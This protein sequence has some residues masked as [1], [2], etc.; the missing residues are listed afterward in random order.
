MQ[1]D[2]P[3]NSSSFINSNE[4][5]N[6]K[7]NSISSKNN[8]RDFIKNPLINHFTINS[9][10]IFD[11]FDF[12]K[13][14]SNLKN[15]NFIKLT[16]SELLFLKT[17]SKDINTKIEIIDNKSFIDVDKDIFENLKKF[18][19]VNNELNERALFFQKEIINSKSRGNISCRK[20]ANTYFLKTWN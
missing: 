16:S 15:K 3:S 20:L 10:F 7:T 19:K 9:F 6:K 2:N 8:V 17:V 11:K 4:F 1:N 5:L 12:S 13:Y 18:F 14:F